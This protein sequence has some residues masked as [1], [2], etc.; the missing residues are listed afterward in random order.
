MERDPSLLLR[1][2]K[3][4]IDVIFRITAGLTIDRY[5]VDELVRPAVERHFEI[6]GEAL[7]RLLRV[8]PALAS[9]VPDV[10]RAIAF[11]NILIHA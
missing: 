5:S 7:N 8:D 3:R 6:L 11:R 4:S 2:V 9:R 1:D 10:E